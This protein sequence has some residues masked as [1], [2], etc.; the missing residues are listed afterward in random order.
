M[1]NYIYLYNECNV[2]LKIFITTLLSLNA[3][4]MTL[5][6]LNA[7]IFHMHMIEGNRLSGQ[8]SMQKYYP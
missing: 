7:L 4:I 8:C 2:H 1:P 3:F 5:L 6:S